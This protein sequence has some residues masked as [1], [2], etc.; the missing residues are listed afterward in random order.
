MDPGDLLWRISVASPKKFDVFI[1]FRGEDTRDNFTSH[2]HAALRD[3]NIVT[4]IDDQL[5]RGD[6]VGL[7]LEKVIKNS[8]MSVVV[9]SE[10]YATSKW[11]LQEL[12]MIT[13]CR[14]DEGQVVLP[15]FYK[16]NPTDVR[17]QTGSYQK[18]FEEYDQA[19]AAG[20]IITD[21]DKVG[22]W[23]AALSE[24]AN[25]SGWDSSTHK[26]DSQV[27]QNIVNDALQ[28][29]LL[30]YPNKLEGL[31]GIEKHCTDIGYI[32]GKV[33]RIGIWGMGGIGKT[34]IAKA[35]FAK[36]FPQYDSVCFLENVREESQKHGLA[37]IRD[38]LLF[39]LLKEQVTASNISGSTFV[40]RRLSSRKVFIVIDD[41]DS[42]EQL[43]YLC[44]E[45]SDLGQGSGLIVT[46]RD[47]HLLHGRVEKIY[48][49][50]KWNLQ[51]SLVLF[52]LAAFKK[53]KPEKGYEDLSR[54][55][56]EYAGGV[57]LALKVLGS[58]FRSRETQFWES[59]LNYLESKKEPLKKIQ[60]VL[61]VSYNG[62]ERR[63]LQSIF[64]DIAF[65]FK[66]ENKDS[67]I[68]IL[69][70]CGF[71]AISGIEMLKDKALISISNSNIIE[72][73]DLLQ[74][75]GFDIVR[76]DVT[77]P[78]RRSRL[79]DIEEVNN[80][81]QNDEVLPEVEGIKLDLSQAVN[82]QLSDD[83]FNRMPNLRFLSLYVPVG[84]QRS[85]EVHFYPG[86]LHRQGS[87]GLKYLEWSGYPSKSLP[88]NFCAKFLVEIRMPHSHVKELW[89]GT[90]DLVNLET[91]D[92][93]ECKQLV[94][95]PDLSKASKLKWVHLSG[96]ESLCLVHLSSVDTLVTLI[97]D[98]CKKLKSLKIEKHLSDLQNLKVENCFSLKEFSVSSDSIQSLDL[99]KTGVKKLYS[100]IGR[101]SK[102]VSLN[103]NGLRL[104]N[105]PNE[106]S[107]LTSLGALFISN[108]GAVDKEKVHVLCA[109]LRSLRFLYLINCYK[110]F[111]LP[112]NISALS[113]LC[114]LRLD[115]SSV[116]KLPTS[117]KLLENLEVLSLN[118]CR[119]L[120]FLPQLP[121]FIQE[122]RIINCTSLVA[123]STL[124]TFAIQMKGK[125][126]D[127]SF[128]NG[129]KLNEH[130]L[131]RIM[132]DAV[133]TMKSAAFHRVYVKRFGFDTYNDHYNRVRVCLPAGNSVP[134]LGPLA[135]RTTGSSITIRNPRP[136]SNWFG[137]IYS[138][139][140]SPSAGIKGHCAKIKCRIYGRVG[141]SGQR[142]WKTSS[143][144]DKDIGEF[145]SDHV[146]V[147]EG[148][149]PHVFTHNDENID[150]VFSV[151]TETGEDDELIK[152]KECGVQLTCFSDSELHR[153][154]QETLDLKPQLSGMQL[155]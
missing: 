134:E 105:I 140:L 60:E 78:G 55:A 152:I 93:S 83:L 18:P 135:Y 132:A 103:L 54:R 133:F 34:T 121:L 122:L 39:E 128:M 94:K 7:E 9:F 76:K 151:T 58:H 62:L 110:L 102:L 91:I 101:L 117:I 86:L 53:S 46:T 50:E 67:V 137:T 20:E 108:C 80:A 90:Q 3:K 69:D 119:K 100:S 31:V 71:N 8:L 144:Y 109:S 22:R 4:Y 33:G 155:R 146:F 21:Q 72:M 136:S 95:L 98:R 44:E 124:K 66:D 113:S 106:L 73:H 49:V 16:T 70:A 97:L 47:K 138:V 43:E 52:S 37:Y 40:K 114:E 147:W 57:P 153:F 96:C 2:L 32:L 125:Q 75:M 64:L 65:F 79:R 82:L 10:R 123:V 118:Y 35:M 126:K 92:L 88:P 107:G 127:I 131:L 36:H 63:D 120:Q 116:K 41:V 25:I 13:K 45:F 59:E 99:S 154:L 142:R 111:E 6:D 27:I 61:K 74:E 143:L 24:A 12:V 84:K 129:M 38:K 141:V 14:R 148:S 85:A 139:V 77:D 115:G 19:A 56:V 5:K 149:S 28:K 51:K 112:D 15:V 23:R 87:A 26:D 48:E 130:S 29:L 68:K 104:Q 150:F 1:S 145:N 17:N 11:C 42:F 30:R 81:L 89:Q